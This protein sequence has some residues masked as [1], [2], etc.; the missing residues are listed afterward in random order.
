MKSGRVAMTSNG[1]VR[2]GVTYPNTFGGLADAVKD[3]PRAHEKAE[4]ASNLFTNG[5][6]TGG[7][8]LAGEVGGIVLVATGT[9]H[10]DRTGETST[11]T[12]SS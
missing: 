9:K 2:D 1:Y 10:D 4:H 6:I 3:N 7:L 12:M 8:G 5:L 11:T